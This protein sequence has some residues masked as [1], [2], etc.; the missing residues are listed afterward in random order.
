MCCV[1]MSYCIKN[2]QSTIVGPGES[3]NFYFSE[4]HLIK[5]SGAH[6]I[7]NEECFALVLEV[8]ENIADSLSSIVKFALNGSSW[9]TYSEFC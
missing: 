5:N 8:P 1:G 2:A 4:V 3:F 6:F 9:Y 7:C